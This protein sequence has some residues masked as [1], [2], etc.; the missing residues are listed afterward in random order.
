MKSRR[1]FFFALGGFT[2]AGLLSGSRAENSAAQKM[3]TVRLIG[4]DGTLT[5]PISVPKV[6][7]TDAEWRQILTDEQYRIARGKGTESC[8]L[9][10]AAGYYRGCLLSLF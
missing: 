6:V 10:T 3:V 7:K 1:E 5:G 8:F 9:G 2:M 4:P